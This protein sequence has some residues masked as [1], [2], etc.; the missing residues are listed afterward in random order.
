[1]L[2]PD[3]RGTANASAPAPDR[4]S[5]RTRAGTPEGASIL[6]RSGPGSCS[7]SPCR[8]APRPPCS[9]PRA[10]T[11][12]ARGAVVN[13]FVPSVCD[14]SDGVTRT[15]CNR[16]EVVWSDRCMSLAEHL[17]G[18]DTAQLTGLLEQRPDVLVEPAP[19]SIRELA[20][21]LDSADSLRIALARVDA[22]EALVI[23]A[24]ALGAETVASVAERVGGSAGQVREIVDRLSTRGLAWFSSDRVEL[25]PR[26]AQQFAAGLTRFRP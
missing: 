20:L 7:V 18:L 26:L 14:H 15:G 25:P 24:V 21:R 8:T 6:R 11:S 5:T 16:D 3:S 4:G 17:A 19:R 22:N 1:M 13:H 2:R 9:L 12:T 23:Q 10:V